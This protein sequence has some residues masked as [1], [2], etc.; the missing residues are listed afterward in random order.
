MFSIEGFT[1]NRSGIVNDEESC[2]PSIEI[3]PSHSHRVV[4]VDKG[5]LL[6][7]VCKRDSGLAFKACIGT[8]VVGVS[9]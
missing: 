7:L 6:L 2:Q 9:L 5:S 1:Q 8:R 4:V 3:K